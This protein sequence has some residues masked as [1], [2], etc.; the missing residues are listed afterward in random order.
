MANYRYFEYFNPNPQP[1]K[2]RGDCSIR[3][4]CAATGLSW[5]E[6]F[7]EMVEVAR[8]NY[9]VLE[10]MDTI[11]EVIENHGFIPYKVTVKRGS[12]RPTMQELIRKY[13]G[14]IIYGQ[15]ANH[16]MC[17]RG[18]K[19]RDIWDSSERPLYKY[20]LKEDTNE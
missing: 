17:A 11:I 3:S 8:K 7:D 2:E 20:W 1:A 18:G 5:M 10:S 9:D 19:V 16:V 6:V 4:I 14:K 13:P 15:C 12:R